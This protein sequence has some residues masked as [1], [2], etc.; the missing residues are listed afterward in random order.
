MQTCVVLIWLNPLLGPGSVP[1]KRRLICPIHATSSISHSHVLIHSVQ[2]VSITVL[3]LT[4]GL[5]NLY[6]LARLNHWAPIRWGTIHIIGIPIIWT[7]E[8]L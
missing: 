7:G 5:W 8:S 2:L 3:E 4:S 6:T 1:Q